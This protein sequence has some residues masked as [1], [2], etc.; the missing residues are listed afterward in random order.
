M[1]QENEIDV[2]ADKLT[3]IKEIADF[4]GEKPRRTRHLIDKGVIPHGYEGNLIV[5]SR[6]RLRREWA[7]TAGA[8]EKS[9]AATV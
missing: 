5:A 4:R 2:G 6:R 9:D 1:S 3:G 8:E 7:K